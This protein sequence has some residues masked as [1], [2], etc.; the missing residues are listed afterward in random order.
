M[1]KGSI[2]RRLE[3]NTITIKGTYSISSKFSK[4]EGIFFSLYK[5]SYLFIMAYL[6]N[7]QI[8]K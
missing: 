4:G 8:L 7:S 1:K 2:A 6:I 3:T 5:S